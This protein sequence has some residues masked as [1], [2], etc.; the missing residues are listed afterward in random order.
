[1]KNK[2]INWIKIH[3]ITLGLAAL[4][5]SFIG[6][7]GLVTPAFSADI[8]TD[9]GTQSIEPQLDRASPAGNWS[10]FYGGLYGD[11]NWKTIGVMG[12]SDIDLSNQKEVGIYGGVNQ[13][14]GNSL[15]G[16]LEIM[17]GYSGKVETENGINAKQNWETSLRARMGY[18]FEQNLVYGLAGVS[19]TQV[20]LTGATGSD[21]QW[22]K[23]W[24]V[25][26]GLERQ[27]TNQITGRI[28]YD[29]SQFGSQQYNIG[30][31]PLETDISGHGLKLGIGLKF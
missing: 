17:G 24:T 22:M 3:T 2:R 12:S 16:G 20:D 26:A 13:D 6:Y 14:L 25:G 30:T 4:S 31:G 19:A 28:E 7:F 23:G 29:Y 27:F 8:T 9:L 1:M 5:S 18:A 15:V 21:Q 10:G 11:L